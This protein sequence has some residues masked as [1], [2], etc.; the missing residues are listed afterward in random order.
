[1]TKVEISRRDEYKAKQRND[2]I[3]S[4]GQ[5]FSIHLFKADKS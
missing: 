4:S 1:M 2:N 5:R 3:A